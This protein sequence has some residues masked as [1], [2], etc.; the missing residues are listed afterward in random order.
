[1]GTESLNDKLARLNMEHVDITPYSPEWPMQ[2]EKEREFLTN[3]LPGSIVRRIEH[4]GSTAVPGLAAKPIIDILVEVS[5][6]EDTKL[7]IVPILEAQNYEYLWRPTIGNSPPYYAWFIKRDSNG[8]RSHHIHMVEADSELW[9]RLLFRDY[10]RQFP[11]EAER[12][13]ELKQMLS[14]E[15]PEDRTAYTVGKSD[16][17]VATTKKAIR[18]FAKN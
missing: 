2:F 11:E 15:H 17:V 6:L 16:Y 18:Y 13:N 4:F 1:M 8:N 5:N 10:L 14:K 9:D 7:H 12:Y 3:I